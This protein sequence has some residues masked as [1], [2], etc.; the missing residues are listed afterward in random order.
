MSEEKKHV[1]NSKESLVP[2]FGPLNGL[3]VID[4]CRYGACHLGATILAEFGAEVIHIDAPP[5]E[6]PTTDSYRFGKPLM[7]PDSENQVSAHGVQNGRNKLS[8]GLDFLKSEEGKRLFKE[9]IKWADIFIE[10]SKP[11]T[12]DRHGLGDEV[13]RNLNTKLS[14]VHLSGYGQTGSKKD[15]LAHDLDIQAYTGFS[16]IVGYEKEP[17]RIPWVIADYVA[18]VWIALSSVLA[19]LTAESNGSGDVVDVAQYEVLVRILDPYYSLLATYPDVE[20]PKRNGNEHPDYF[21]Y[22][23]YKCTDGWVSVSAPF[24][25]TWVRMRKLLGF[26]P[27]YDDIK[28][29]ES[30]RR[31][32]E[33]ALNGW[34]SSMTVEQVEKILRD[35]G[36]PASKV[37]SI[38]DFL[39]DPHVKERNLIASWMDENI[40]EVRGLSIVPNFTHNPGRIWRGFPKVGQDTQA[41]LQN[42]VGL[43]DETI[44]DL[45]NRGV[46][47]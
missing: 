3:K 29:R 17:L 33:E 23:F 22:G 6:P 14:I 34:L 24:P 45:R 40:G 32:I 47:S 35:Q 41:I 38:R 7:P 46:I 18:S 42:I 19:H 25:A 11:G 15:D 16:S 26:P 37:N 39:N 8:L 5:F 1:M 4:T 43:S 36:I 28:F 10:A 20:A 31:E 2:K 30:K 13:L 9:L 44:V 21:P 27:S 12:L